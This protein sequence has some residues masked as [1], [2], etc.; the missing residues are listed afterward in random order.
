MKSPL[1][2]PEIPVIDSTGEDDIE[3]VYQREPVEVVDLALEDETL[4][5]TSEVSSSIVLVFTQVVSIMT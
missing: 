2:S 5:P 1:K 3:E 4:S